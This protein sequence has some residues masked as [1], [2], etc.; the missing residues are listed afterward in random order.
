MQ[1]L[2]KKSTLNYALCCLVWSVALLNAGSVFA[3]PPNNSSEQNGVE[4]LEPQR[5]EVPT[6][7]EVQA[8]AK[9]IKNGLSPK[10]SAET[11]TIA[12]SWRQQKVINDVNRLKLQETKQ[13]LEYAK[14]QNELVKLQLQNESLLKTKQSPPQ[15]KDPTEGIVLTSIYADKKGILKA[16]LA[17]LRGRLTVVKGHRLGKFV[18]KEIGTQHVLLM[19]GDEVYPLYV[20]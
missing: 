2:N 19:Q 16:T 7:D 8:A 18:V 3:A 11:L 9:L 14:L 5:A 15:K 6:F 13:N 4:R 1:V 12:N 10:E 20:H 17:T